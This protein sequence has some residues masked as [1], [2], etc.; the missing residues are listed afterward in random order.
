MNDKWLVRVQEDKNGEMF[1]T[2]P[3]KLLA[4]LGWEEGDDVT[5]HDNKNGTWTLKKDE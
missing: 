5:W 2:L 3:V 4:T 1:L